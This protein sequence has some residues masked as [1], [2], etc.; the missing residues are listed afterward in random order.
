MMPYARVARLW[1]QCLQCHPR[2]QGRPLL[3]HRDHNK[4][5]PRSANHLELGKWAPWELS[6]RLRGSQLPRN[7]VGKGNSPRP[8]QLARAVVI[9]AIYDGKMLCE[10]MPPSGH[11]QQVGKQGNKWACVH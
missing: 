6:P 7:A 9:K 11:D 8:C 3:A 5:A 4:Q 10:A 2:R 1:R